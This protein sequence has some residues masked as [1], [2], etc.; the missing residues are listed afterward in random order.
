M[1]GRNKYAV[2]TDYLRQCTEKSIRFT[3]D[4]LNAIV[5]IPSSAYYDRSSW[6]NCTTK[7]KTPFQRSWMDTEYR[8]KDIKTQEK[9]VL[10]TKGDVTIHHE[11]QMDVIKHSGPTSFEEELLITVPNNLVDLSKD[12]YLMVQLTKG[13]SELVE[14]CIAK[15]RKYQ[16]NGKAIMKQWF[17][18]GNYS[19]EAYYQILKSIVKENSTRTSDETVSCLAA[20]C[21]SNNNSFLDRLKAGDIE[22]VDDIS[23]YL[24]NSGRRK[25]KSLASKLCRYLNEWLFDDCAYTINDSVVR[26]I[27]PY[28][29]A[30]YKIDRNLWFGK[31]FEA[32]SYK[33]FYLLFSNV[34]DKVQVLN[35]HQLDHLIWYSYKNDSVRS[36][37][38]KALALVL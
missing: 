11:K 13:N 24:T 23:L 7:N 1:A 20:Y 33:D 34:R 28:Y 5:A 4:E 25:E 6:A 10:F 19:K 32:L 30:Y 31:D 37:V 3:F 17:S 14:S 15:D 27:L 9:W 8:V 35:N 12:E 21:A 16:S 18:V 2:L 22:L 36:A 38:A 29:L 26:A